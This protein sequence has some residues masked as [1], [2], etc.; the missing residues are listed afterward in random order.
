MLFGFCYLLLRFFGVASLGI[1][2]RAEAAKVTSEVAR[3]FL[4]KIVDYAL[5]FIRLSELEVSRSPQPVTMCRN[6]M[7]TWS[8]VPRCQSRFIFPL[9]RLRKS[10]ERQ[11]P[12]RFD[13]GRVAKR[14]ASAP[15]DE[16]L[17]ALSFVRKARSQVDHA[18]DGGIV[19]P[20]LE[21]KSAERGEAL[22]DADSEGEFVSQLR[23][24]FP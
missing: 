19:P 11:G 1:E 8:V 13:I 3:M 5:R 7:F 2:H 24:L 17:T 12:Q 21:A 20:S 18:A 6:P 4:Q 10:F 23:P 9:V 22:S 16:N 14:R 15:V